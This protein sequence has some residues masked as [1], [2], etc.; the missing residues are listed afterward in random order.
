M[1][2]RSRTPRTPRRHGTGSLCWDK[3]REGWRARA[4]P[5][6]GQRITH[7]F[8]PENGSA[9]AIRAAEDLA[10]NWLDE[11]K[12]DAG[13]GTITG[14]QLEKSNH[15]PRRWTQQ[16]LEDLAAKVAAG[17]KARRTLGVTGAIWNVRPADPREDETRRPRR[18]EDRPLVDWTGGH[19]EPKGRDPIRC[20]G[21]PGYRS[22][23]KVLTDARLGYT[24][25]RGGATSN[26]GPRRR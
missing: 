10:H 4:V 20:D 3:D 1:T 23:H 22:L 9:Q 19:A 21:G 11:F 15:H 5:I 24:R 25:Q 26:P 13:R 7:I 14:R 16:W 8:V 6:D 2:S 17:V 18:G 12:V